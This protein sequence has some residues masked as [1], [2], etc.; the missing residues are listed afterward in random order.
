MPTL[1]QTIHFWRL[2]RG[3][4]QAKLA[5]LSGTSRPSI[6]FFE[7]E[8]RDM[9]VSTLNR[10]ARALRVSPG[11]LADGIFQAEA[12]RETGEI[13]GSA[14]SGALSRETLDGIA[15]A[16]IGEKIQLSNYE[17][18]LAALFKSIL[19]RKLASVKTGFG[20]GYTLRLPRTARSEVL[21]LLELKT[22]LAPSEIGNVL[23]RIDKLIG[24]SK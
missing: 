12:E 16:V 19:K 15:H 23:S 2:K 5:K 14:G 21:N 9:A 17:E 8:T 4:S 11:T 22:L 6:S 10:I 13:P 7:Q 1:G 20:S 24:S 18:K 3:F